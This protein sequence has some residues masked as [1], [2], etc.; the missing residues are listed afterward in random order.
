MAV[1]FVGEVICLVISVNERDLSLLN[2]VKYD[3]HL[4]ISLSDCVPNARKFEASNKLSMENS[5]FPAFS[6]DHMMQ[7]QRER[8][9]HFSECPPASQLIALIVRCCLAEMSVGPAELA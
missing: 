4:I 8:K 5:S 1:F 7:Y 2:S 3:S 6:C 9:M